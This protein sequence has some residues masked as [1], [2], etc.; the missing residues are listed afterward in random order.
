MMA[1]DDP[2]SPMNWPLYRR[3]YASMAAF[4]FAWIVTFT[5]TSYTAA[6]PDITTEFNVTVPVA[7]LGLALYLFGVFFAP[8]ITPHLSESFGRSLVYLISLPISSLFIIGVGFS[9][10][11][12]SLAVCRFFAGLFAGPSVVLIEGTF[13]DIWSAETTNTY[14]SFLGFAQYLGAACGPLILNFIVPATSWRWT[15]YVPLMFTLAALLFGIGIPE[16][17]QR[18]ILRRR[19]RRHNKPIQLAPAGSGETMKERV[20]VTV[21][22]PLNMLVTE[23]LV[24]GVTLYLGLNFAVVF[25]WF[26]TVPVVLSSVYDF[27]PQ[28]IGL[29]FISA[30]VGGVC[31]V[32]TSIAFETVSNGVLRKRYGNG[33]VPIE[34]RLYPAMVGS[35]AIVASLFW[36]GWTA[37]PMVSSYV[38][39]TGTGFYVYGN[40]CVLISLI[41]YIFDAYPPP[42]TLAALTLMACFRLACAGVVPLV[43]FYM[44]NNLTGAWALST[45]GFISAPFIL[46][47]FAM[48]KFGPALRAR[49]KFSNA[50]A[51]ATGW[52]KEHEEGAE[53]TA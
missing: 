2:D 32:V 22:D 33:M 1:P 49:S 48:F 18:E 4:F 13:A 29:A 39:I 28:Q 44:F 37:D 38:P 17:Y 25:Q 41:P 12:A 8:I 24:I 35:F 52:K 47:P 53:M 19:A 14:Y 40:L 34:H 7:V 6:I 45:F 26:I 46:L 50:G 51:M 42:G 31:A 9:N 36:V 43:V 16:T 23:P 30:I 11:F 15:Q 20:Q 27:R 10:T 3:I 5:A 21:L